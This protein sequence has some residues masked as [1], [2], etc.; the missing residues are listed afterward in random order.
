MSS[1]C[2]TE[3]SESRSGAPR[4]ELTVYDSTC[5]IVG[6]IVGA[7][8]YRISP[9]V[10]AKSPGVAALTALWLL[11][12]AFALLGSLCYAELATAYPK[13]GGDYVYLTRALGRP[14]GFLFAWC[15]LWIVRPGSIGVMAYAFAE[16][17]NRIWPQATGAAGVR[18]TVAYA[19][20][21][22]VALTAINLLGV[23]EGKWTQNVL[24]TVKALGL[25]AVVVVGFL[26]T[27]SHAIALQ[28]LQH[29]GSALP[30]QAAA[31]SQR[32]DWWNSLG[33]LGTAMVLVL[34]TY[35]GW[36]EMAYVAAEVRGSRR[37]IL[38]AL[39]IGTL[40]VTAAY[41][42]INLAFVHALG[43][44]GVGQTKA[45]AADVLELAIGPW[46]SVCISLLI[47]ISALSAV[48][49]Q[50][51]T[52]SRIYYAMGTEHRFYAWLGRW[53]A[54]RGT[55]DASLL[56]QGA[57]TLALVV[58]FGLGQNGFE[59]MV[60]FTTPCF[61]FFLALVGVSLI[62]LRVREPDVERPYRVP[63]YPMTPILLSLGSVCLVYSGLLY[64]I[65]NRT[66]EALWSTLA[67]LATG[68][69]V[70][71]AGAATDCRRRRARRS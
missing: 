47:C 9:E 5:I 35:G 2:D 11:G 17:A 57:I 16:F 61:W 30:A 14:V 63:G 44:V 24:T 36:N 59:Q 51:F 53:N 62:V 70:V 20:G 23:R 60:I 19:A 40:A 32:L 3:P 67:V 22:V 68:V 13:E 69:L 28:P 55:P 66:P 50:I 49:G 41:I 8:I 58:W 46:A 15:Q 29:G 18:V 37:N 34:F 38:H 10:A 12:G 21:A 6:I 33:S 45:P 4:R 25:V 64:A 71:L 27:S 48:N 39:L 52:G 65:R 43:F 31:A 54:R 7:G 42:L 26:F 1:L 56:I